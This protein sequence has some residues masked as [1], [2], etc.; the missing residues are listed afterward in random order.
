MRQIDLFGGNT[1]LIKQLL[2]L[3]SNHSLYDGSESCFI[4]KQQ[5]KSKFEL[6]S[7][8]LLHIKRFDF[9]FLLFL[10]YN[11]TIYQTVLS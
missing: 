1:S 3:P 6:F 2:Y 5:H 4:Q 11:A 8:P 9:F 10:I 7:L